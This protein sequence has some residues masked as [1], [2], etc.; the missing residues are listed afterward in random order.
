[1]IVGFYYGGGGARGAFLSIGLSLGLMVI[2]V[3]PSY[4]LLAGVLVAGTLGT[5]VYRNFCQRQWQRLLR[6]LR[7]DGTG[8]VDPSHFHAVL[9]RL[10]E[11]PTE[12]WQPAADLSI[13]ELRQRLR[14]RDRNVL[15]R[16]DLERAYTEAYDDV[17][18]ICAEPW[19]AGDVLRRLKPCDHH[20]H[21]ECIDRWAMTSADKGRTPLCPLCK[22]KF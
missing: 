3:I 18:A 13:R 12:K 9:G 10:R 11:M 14:G 19:A 7:N 15:E 20:F 22:A 17:C 1:M 2:N 16:K 6:F 4:I 5:F 21:I 8:P